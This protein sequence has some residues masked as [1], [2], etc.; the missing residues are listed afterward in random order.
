MT[1]GDQR[2]RGEIRRITQQGV[3]HDGRADGS[4]RER[5]GHIRREGVDHEGLVGTERAR[6]TWRH[7]R[8]R[9]VVARSILQRAAGQRERRARGNVEITGVIARLHGIAEGERGCT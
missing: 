2:R 5:R 3:R 4:E 9:C 6:G 1:W 8:E 7:E